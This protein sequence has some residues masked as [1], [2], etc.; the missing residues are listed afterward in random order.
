[1]KRSL[2]SLTQIAPMLRGGIYSGAYRG[3][4]DIQGTL[5]RTASTKDPAACRAEAEVLRPRVCQVVAGSARSA[6]L[7]CWIRCQV[8]PGISSGDATSS[9]SYQGRQN[10]RSLGAPGYCRR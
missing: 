10:S 4:G 1:M 8:S 6:R 7:A 3:D 5:L 2:A 9:T